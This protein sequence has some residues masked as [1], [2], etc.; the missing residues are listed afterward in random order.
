MQDPIVEKIIQRAIEIQQIPAPTFEERERAEFVRAKF[1]EEG[2]DQVSMDSI[3][4]VFA[5]LPGE[6]RSPLLVV[7]A[8]TDTVFPAEADLT[9]NRTNDRIAGPGIGDN[10]L[11]VAGLFGLLWELRRQ[12][13]RLPGDLWL[14]AN[15]GE[16]GLGDLVGMKKVVERFGDTPL[17]YIV[18]EGL[19]FGRLYHRGLGVRRYRISVET[20]G[21]HSWVDYG[22]PSAIHE[23][24]VIMGDILALRIPY[25]RRTSINIGKISGGV[26]INTIAP[27]ASLDLDLRSESGRVL[28]MLSRK[29]EN[30]V[31]IAKRPGVKFT[32][33]V[34]GNREYGEIPAD[35]PLVQIGIDAISRQDIE[36]DLLIGS[37]DA[38]V[39]L[40]KGIP[41]I[42]IG[43]SNGGG[44]HTKKEYISLEFIHRGIK[45]LVDVVVNAYHLAGK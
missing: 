25:R 37:T 34:I 41:A 9:L 38:N 20:M 29:V 40:S 26:S 11:G 21:G 7:S 12:D 18:L 23:L 24:S 31:Q 33:E 32:C 28:E 15:V 19:A 36:P 14:V 2:L 3:G 1:E 35:H 4:D 43:L 10:S 8:H 17:G 44:A 42:C 22:N 27:H 45:Q 30:I 5:R 13:I 39:P 6:T 16:E